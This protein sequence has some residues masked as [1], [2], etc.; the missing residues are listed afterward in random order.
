MVPDMR[1]WLRRISVLALLV[2]GV[3]ALRLVLWRP[4]AVEVVVAAAERGRVDAT[5]TN[6]RAGTVRVRRRALLSP[7]VSGLVVELPFRAGDRVE[8]GDLLVRL[9]PRWYEARRLHARHSL[10]AA[11]A[12]HAESCIAAQRAERE[13]ARNQRIAEER[14]I[15]EDLLDHFQS[16]LDAAVAGCQTAAAVVEQAAAELAVVEAELSRTGIRAPFAGVVAERT[17]EQGEYIMPSP[18]GVPIPPVI[19]LIDTSSVYVSA[20]MDEVDWARIR[21]GL[22]ARVTLDPFPGEEHRGR[23]VRVAPYVLDVREQNRTVEIEVELEDEELA[24][25]LLPGTSADV[26]VVVDSRADA[27]RVPSAALLEGGR[28]L[29]L[30]DG[31]LHERRLE[32][33]LRNWDWAEVR[34]GLEAGAL[35]VTSLGRTEVVAGARALARPE[36]SAR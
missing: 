9:D 11:R 2:V 29:V 27:L 26:E 5:V 30:E 35:V 13:L 17:V 25:R 28:V 22:E 14:L 24:A 31:R 4:Q 19:D 23:V 33:G 21:A 7:E 8:A 6:T 36:R 34:G 16:A 32:L 3:L 1:A 12:R 18:P 15:S 20:P 10:E